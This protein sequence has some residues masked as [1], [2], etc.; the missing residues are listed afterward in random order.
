M[1][2]LGVLQPKYRAGHR[3]GLPQR[4]KCLGRQGL[5]VSSPTPGTESEVGLR[6]STILNRGTSVSFRSTT[7][8]TS[9][10]SY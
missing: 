7:R 6:G 1:S 2:S 3:L 5:Y 8:F 4:A 10:F 9:H